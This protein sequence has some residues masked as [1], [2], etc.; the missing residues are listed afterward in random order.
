[1]E[2]AT[3]MR[4]RLI[5][6][7]VTGMAIVGMAS[8]CSAIGYVAGRIVDN[9]LTEEQSLPIPSADEIRD[10][11]VALPEGETL[12]VCTTAGDFY[13]GIYAGPRVVP[14][15]IDGFRLA[16]AL[17]SGYARLLQED[18]LGSPSQSLI[19]AS[20]EMRLGRSGEFGGENRPGVQMPTS[21]VSLSR[22]VIKAD[23]LLLLTDDGPRSIPVYE[24]DGI[25]VARPKTV[26]T[27]LVILGA[28]TDFVLLQN[29]LGI[30]LAT[31]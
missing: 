23:A 13:E 20:R 4:T 12:T 25:T 29:A 1:M 18:I 22:V 10:S 17:E 26:T 21:A 3:A 7:L 14:V 2:K 16:E 31:S 28:L 19:L 8:G 11:V 27:R 30:L 5:L 9:T 24:I 6:F 15:S